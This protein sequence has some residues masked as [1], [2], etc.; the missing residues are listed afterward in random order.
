MSSHLSEMP[1]LFETNEHTIMVI[2][3][4]AN[5][6]TMIMDITLHVPGNIPN[7]EVARCLRESADGLENGHVDFES[8]YREVQD[9]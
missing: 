7:H 9:P 2:I 3:V 5:P 4:D 6:E 1:R 8:D